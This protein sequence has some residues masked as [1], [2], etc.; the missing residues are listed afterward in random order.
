M[1]S[2]HRA[3]YFIPASSPTPELHDNKAML[4]FDMEQPN[5]QLIYS[6]NLINLI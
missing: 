6:S 4:G 2:M 5:K 1:P 3:L